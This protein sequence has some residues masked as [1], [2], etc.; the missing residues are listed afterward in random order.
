MDRTLALLRYLLGAFV[1]FL[2]S[3]A[4]ST[5]LLGYEIN[6]N[7]SGTLWNVDSTAVAISSPRPTIGGFVGLD[8]DSAGVLFGLTSSTVSAGA[9]TNSL[10]T[11]N[12]ATGAATLVGATGM[13]GILEGDLAFDPSTGMLWGGYQLATP[14][15]N[16]FTI[17]T[18]TGASSFRFA[19]PV[20]LTDFSG[21]AF[22]SAGN[23]FLLNTQSGFTSL[24]HVDKVTGAV[25]ATRALTDSGNAALLTGSA[26]MDFD[27]L[28]GTMYLTDSGTKVLYSLD[29]STGV[30]NFLRGGASLFAGAAAGLAVLPQA[31]VVPEPQSWMLVG[32]ALAWLAF[33]STTRSRGR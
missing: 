21:M 4:H 15:A 33:Y 7:G 25:I 8:F 5:L 16:F 27:P 29:T 28:T 11:L 26:G 22:D 24:L 30:L 17:N 10:Y 20:G 19:L 18:A 31:Q 14:N 3:A 32:L 1:V 23:L 12:T 13:S 2:S 6:V 9:N